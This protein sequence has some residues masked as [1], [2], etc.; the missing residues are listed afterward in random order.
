MLKPVGSQT[1][2]LENIRIKP[3]EFWYIYVFTLTGQSYDI[4][5]R[6]RLKLKPAGPCLGHSALAVRLRVI[7][8]SVV[9][10]CCTADNVE[11]H[12]DDKHDNVDNWYFPP[13]MTDA[14][15]DA[16][17]ARVTLVAQLLLVVAPSCAVWIAKHHRTAL[18][19]VRLISI[20]KTTWCWRL[21]AAWLHTT[22]KNFRN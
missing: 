22:R 15:K 1:K 16:G 6:Y 10:E 4:R 17:F 8:P 7:N 5:Y 20:H 21:A 14:G 9:S 3:F 2:T 11:D 13:A 19:P 18:V 12:E